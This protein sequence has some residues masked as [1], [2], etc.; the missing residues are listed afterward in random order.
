[1]LLYDSFALS[2]LC[3]QDLLEPYN[4]MKHS[5]ETAANKSPRCQESNQ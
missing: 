4:Y 3:G 1:M 2:R 5:Q